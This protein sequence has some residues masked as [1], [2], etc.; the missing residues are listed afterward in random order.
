MYTIPILFLSIKY[1]FALH[2]II[3]L[4]QYRGTTDWKN[5]TYAGGVTGGLIGIRGEWC[6][7]LQP[8]E[9]NLW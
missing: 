9:M 5:G 2:N 1:C 3:L 8:V 4:L 6:V 7:S